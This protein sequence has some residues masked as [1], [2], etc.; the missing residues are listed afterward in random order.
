M[1]ASLK[2]HMESSPHPFIAQPN[3]T[4]IRLSI[5]VLVSLTA[6]PITALVDTAFISSMGVVPLAALGVGTT[7][8]S[9][10]FWMFGFLGVGAQ[11]EIAQLFGRGK[12]DQAGGILSLTLLLSALAGLLIILA[13]SPTA[14]GL[15]RVLGASGAVQA[16]AI[17]YTRIRLFGAPAV[18]LILTISGALRGIQDMRTPLWIALGVNGLNI[19]LDWLLIFGIGPFPALGVEGSALASTISQWFGALLGLVL[20]TQKIKPS[21]KFQLRETLKILRIGGDMF[22]R[23]GMLNLFLIYTT[24][25]ANQI[26]PNSG[27][28]HQVLRQ[29]WVFTAL[30]LD[31]FAATVQSLVGFFI[32]RGSVPNAKFVVKIAL[33]WSLGTGIA[34]SALMAAGQGFVIRHL[35]PASAA[36]VFIPAWLVSTLSQPLNSIAFLTDGVHLGTGDYGFLRNAV[37]TSSLIGILGLWLLE[38]NGTSTLYWIWIL[39]TVWIVL[40]GAIGLLRIWPGIGNSP[41]RLDDDSSLQPE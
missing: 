15:T 32:G 28:A 38:R 16:N 24:R 10:L 34:L 11:T 40:R 29:M 37:L 33:A 35:V 21:R 26:S 1:A 36:A 2:P 9:S 41:F 39:I 7:A 17:R 23:T 14:E 3:R 20:V 22:I 30:A 19:V 6:E 12:K 27:A 25:A 4:L 31:A 5:P 18:L 13:I 8:L